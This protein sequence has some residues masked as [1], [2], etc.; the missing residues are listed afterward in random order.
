MSKTKGFIA[1]NI[2]V[3]TNPE[4][5]YPMLINV[6]HIINIQDDYQTFSGLRAAITT[7]E[8]DKDGT[9]RIYT[10][11]ESYEEIRNLIYLCT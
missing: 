2:A 5:T 8:I 10:V 9:N 3:A 7:T 4:D 11:I 6:N 1:V